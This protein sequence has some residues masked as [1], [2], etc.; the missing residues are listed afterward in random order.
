MLLIPFDSVGGTEV[1]HV[2]LRIIG[3]ATPDR[4]ATTLV[5]PFAGPSLGSFSHGRVF[6]SFRRIAGYRVEAPYQLAGDGVVSRY[7]STHTVLGAAVSDDYF[8][9]EHARRRCDGVG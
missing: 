8:V 1:E 3:D 6:E 9:V 2:E 7:V 5:P 4:A